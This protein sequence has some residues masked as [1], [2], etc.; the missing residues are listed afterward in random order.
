MRRIRH[1]EHLYSFRQFHEAKR[2]E[3]FIRDYIDSNGGKSLKY[4]VGISQND[5]TFQTRIKAHSASKN[6]LTK[7]EKI[8]SRFNRIVKNT[9]HYFTTRA[10]FV[11]PDYHTD[12]DTGGSSH[13]TILYIFKT[14]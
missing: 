10:E 1:N 2:L 13:P 12:G 9:E 3:K 4:Y 5:S 7:P 6:I 8:T 11:E 14:A